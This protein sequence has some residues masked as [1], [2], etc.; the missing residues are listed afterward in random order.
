MEEFSEFHD[1]I[2]LGD[3]YE[4]PLG[5]LI[6]KGS[7]ILLT[8]GRCIS[9]D[10]HAQGS[11]RIQQTCMA[12]GEAAAVLAALSVSKNIRPREVNS[13]EVVEILA[14]IRG[15]QEPA[16]DILASLPGISAGRPRL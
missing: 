13:R 14:H 6:P 11:L 5:C 4:I 10:V 7:D 9:A 2:A 16:F 15:S 12:T 8:A 3:Y 1:K